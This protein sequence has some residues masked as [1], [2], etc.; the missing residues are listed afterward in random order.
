MWSLTFYRT[1]RENDVEYL[2][3]YSVYDWVWYDS[4]EALKTG[5]DKIKSVYKNKSLVFQSIDK[6]PMRINVMLSLDGRVVEQDL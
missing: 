4:P 6:I 2:F 3:H 1:T 5:L